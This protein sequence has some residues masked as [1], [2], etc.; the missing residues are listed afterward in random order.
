MSTETTDDAHEAPSRAIRRI[1]TIRDSPPLLGV[2][3]GVALL[4]IGLALGEGAVAGMVG[5]Y[6]AT[7]VLV[8]ATAHAVLTVLRRN[9]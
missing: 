1:A 6:G 9:Q 7:V 8:S 4:G 5:I 3:L 2:L